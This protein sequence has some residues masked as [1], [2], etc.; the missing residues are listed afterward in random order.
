MSGEVLYV[1]P[2]IYYTFF[3]RWKNNNDNVL[4]YCA[5]NDNYYSAFDSNILFKLYMCK[6]LFTIKQ[7]SNYLI[8]ANGKN[9]S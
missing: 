7:I 9:E 2:D 1:V 6:I 8:D 3:G 5:S 4:L